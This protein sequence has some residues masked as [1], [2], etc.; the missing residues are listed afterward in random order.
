[1]PF[2]TPVFDGANEEE[3]KDMLE[4]AGSADVD[5]QIDAVRRPHRRAPS[6]G[7]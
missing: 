5:G 3:I 2:A 4:L 6:T 7:R 1:M